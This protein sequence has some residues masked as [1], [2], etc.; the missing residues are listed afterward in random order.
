MMLFTPPRGGVLL[1][2]KWFSM[3][4]GSSR[5]RN[6]TNIK[7]KG[8]NMNEK[9]IAEI[10]N[11]LRG[12]DTA[13][14][15]ESGYAIGVRIC[16]QD[17]LQDLIDKEDIL[18]SKREC[19]NTVFVESIY[20]ARPPEEALQCLPL[21]DRQMLRAIKDAGYVVVETPSTLVIE[22]VQE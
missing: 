21:K 19:L 6:K 17:P 1:L 4:G 7:R 9:L 15:E 3:I 14:I 11:T 8:L 5:A 2:D 10:L 16:G 12:T 18:E 22:K 20:T 13:H